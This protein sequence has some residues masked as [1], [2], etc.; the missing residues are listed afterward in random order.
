MVELEDEGGP[1]AK[2]EDSIFKSR[3][4]ACLARE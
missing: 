1:E 2:D 4:E 3:Q